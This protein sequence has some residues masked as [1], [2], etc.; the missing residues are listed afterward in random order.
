MKTYTLKTDRHSELKAVP[1]FPL[2]ESED[3]KGVIFGETL[4]IKTPEKL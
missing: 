4:L 2:L 3:N 1:P